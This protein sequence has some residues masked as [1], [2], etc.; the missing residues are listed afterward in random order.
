VRVVILCGG[1]GTRAYP[2]TRRVP[3]ALMPIAGIPVVEQ[4]MRI[5]A[6]QGF[7]D[8]V[9]S[10][11]YLKEE[12]VRYFADRPHWS[13]ECVDTGDT[14]DT[15]GR[16]RG[17]LD[18]LGETF[19]ATYCDGLGDVNLAAL[20]AFHRGHGDSA[21]LT[22]VPLRSQYGILKAD[23]EER[24]VGFEEKP[25]LPEYWINAGFFV[26]ERDAFAQTP[27][28]NLEQDVLPEMAR[29]GIVRAYRHKGFWRS[30]DTQKDQLELDRLWASHSIRL[31]GHVG[32]GHGAAIPDW[33]S[34]R[35]E[36]AEN[37]FA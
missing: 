6:S 35:Y 28:D 17:C 34:E 20:V 11:G 15:A 21:T 36:H 1:R 29:R 14:R 33:L 37:E 5:Y 27:G 12:I 22:S 4:V 19:L 13:V 18:R 23:E 30:M 31:D 16:I 24:I 25:V 8:F 10:V 26:F 3:K 7:H 2:Y 9:L 32:N